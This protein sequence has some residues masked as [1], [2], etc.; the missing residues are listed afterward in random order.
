MFLTSERPFS[1][2]SWEVARRALYNA[3]RRCPLGGVVV[4]FP[5]RTVASYLCNPAIVQARKGRFI[6]CSPQV[7]EIK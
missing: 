7:V 3:W 1:R 2:G 5:Q 6:S 4:R